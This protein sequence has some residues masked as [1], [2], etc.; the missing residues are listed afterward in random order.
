[1]TR[2]EGVNAFIRQDGPLGMNAVWKKNGATCYL[3]LNALVSLVDRRGTASQDSE[4]G[5]EQELKVAYER[6]SNF[7]EIV[8]GAHNVLTTYDIAR[9]GSIEVRTRHA[10]E[11]GAK[12]HRDLQEKL[13]RTHDDL[14]RH[15]KLAEKAEKRNRFLL[16]ANES[17]GLRVS[18]LNQE[19]ARLERLLK[20]HT[21]HHQHVNDGLRT[22]LRDAKAALLGRPQGLP[23]DAQGKAWPFIPGNQHG[24]TPCQIKWFSGHVP[25]PDLEHVPLKDLQLMAR[26]F[27]AEQEIARRQEGLDTKTRKDCGNLRMGKTEAMLKKALEGMRAG[28]HVTVVLH[29]FQHAKKVWMGIQ[30]DL[31]SSEKATHSGCLLKIKSLGTSG[32]IRFSNCSSHRWSARKTEDSLKTNDWFFVDHQAADSLMGRACTF[33]FPC[34][35]KAS[36]Q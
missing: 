15:A 30:Q 6:L 8:Q 13:N 10:L 11:E 36:G 31:I 23:V 18:E 1:M 27:K 16:G 34:L 33:N 21:E 29:N 7:E 9:A 20:D 19:N 35:K 5:L 28:K 3:P 32:E 2:H 26:A 14:K 17:W 4:S 22:R 24:Y 25:D 12:I